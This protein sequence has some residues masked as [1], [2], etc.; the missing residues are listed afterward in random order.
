MAS[1]DL[2]WS[3]MVFHGLLWQNIDLIGLESSFLV[4]IDPNSFGLVKILCKES[5]A[6]FHRNTVV[7]EYILE[8]L[9]KFRHS[10]NLFFKSEKTYV[11]M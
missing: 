11:K 2:L 5:S 10:T 3:C 8:R 6:I 9:R 1:S 7:F 4:V